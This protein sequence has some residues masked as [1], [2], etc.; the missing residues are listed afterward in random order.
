M[1]VA[2][3]SPDESPAV[4]PRPAIGTD[5]PVGPNRAECSGPADSGAAQELAGDADAA[6]VDSVVLVIGEITRLPAVTRLPG[7]PGWL[8]GLVNWRGTVLAVVD[9]AGLLGE[10]PSRPAADA[11]LVVLDLAEASVG[12]ACARVDGLLDAAGTVADGAHPGSG[13]L[14][15]H[16]VVDGQPVGLLDARALGA[17]RGLLPG[18]G[19][20]G[21][22]ASAAG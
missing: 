1:A 22:P 19:A 18:L 9:P 13:L 2:P 21:P 8:T 16:A 12:L 14:R 17:L 6:T 4:G 5:R 11:R 10:P 20:A 3:G 15:G 7:V